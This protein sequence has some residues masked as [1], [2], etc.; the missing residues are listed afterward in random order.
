MGTS[1]RVTTCEN[2]TS[3]MHHNSP[4]FFTWL[5]FNFAFS[6]HSMF[7]LLLNDSMTSLI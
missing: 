6:Y 1:S 4:G 5:K 2:L 3:V 7:G